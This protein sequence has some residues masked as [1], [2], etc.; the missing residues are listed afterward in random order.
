MNYW[1]TPTHPNARTPRQSM[2]RAAHFAAA[3]LLTAA[4][5][6]TLTA[7]IIITI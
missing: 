5:I 3:V 4:T 6:A 7:L 2:E 1:N